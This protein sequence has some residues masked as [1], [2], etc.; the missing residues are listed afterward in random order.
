MINHF[1]S[2]LYNKVSAPENGVYTPLAEELSVPSPLANFYKVLSGGTKEG[3]ELLAI[4][5]V[6]IVD[7]SQYRDRLTQHDTRITF[8]PV[9]LVLAETDLFD[10]IQEVVGLPPD[11][12]NYALQEQELRT[13]FRGG[14]KVTHERAAAV[15]VGVVNRMTE[16]NA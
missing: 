2:V 13:T 11:T 6:K 1:F 15:L 3:A 7:A 8:D 5:G 4:R 9:D 14:T 16:A 10:F 12:V